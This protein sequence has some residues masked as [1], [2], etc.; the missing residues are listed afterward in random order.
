LS[1]WKK[2]IREA[3]DEGR[4][5]GE[6][7]VE[8]LPDDV[9][10]ALL[11]LDGALHVALNI[12]ACRD[13]QAKKRVARVQWTYAAERTM[14]ARY[15]RNTYRYSGATKTVDILGRYGWTKLFDSVT[16]LEGA[17]RKIRKAAKK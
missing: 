4:E 6:R 15:K 8:S 7:H 3:I 9:K 11:K 14:V 1:Q 5:V 2:N 17:S 13:K 12:I 10:W 16:S